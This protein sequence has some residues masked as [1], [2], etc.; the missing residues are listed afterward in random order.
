MEGRLSSMSTLR[1]ELDELKREAERVFEQEISA[2]EEELQRLTSSRIHIVSEEQGHPGP[3]SALA[4]GP[5]PL[6]QR[7]RNMADLPVY[8]DT[9]MPDTRQ[10][11]APNAGQRRAE[12]IQTQGTQ[13][14]V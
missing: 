8:D 10:R 2:G 6:S 13:Q 9:P 14:R 1:A 4:N 12:E 11:K 3:F 7:P 5:P